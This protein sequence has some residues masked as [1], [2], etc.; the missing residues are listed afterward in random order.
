MRVIITGAAGRIGSQLV[1]ELSGSHEL[2]LIDRRQM[3]V[4]NSIVADLSTRPVT[5]GWRS[6]FK[7]KSWRWSDAFEKADVVVHLAANIEPLAPWQKVLP[8]NIQ[9]T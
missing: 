3:E 9:A 7:T 6:W 2:C 8:D 1:A 4:K 5:N